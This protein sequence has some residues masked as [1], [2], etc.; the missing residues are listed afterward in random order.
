M[1]ADGL[2]RALSTEERRELIVGGSLQ[3]CARALT[4]IDAL[5]ATIAEQAAHIVLDGRR[6]AELEARLIVLEPPRA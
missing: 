1:S 4:L 5:T 2:P 6:I 3:V